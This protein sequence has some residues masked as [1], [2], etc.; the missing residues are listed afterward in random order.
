MAGADHPAD[1]L[2]CVGADMRGFHRSGHYIGGEISEGG[3]GC[4]N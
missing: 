2:C 3:G 1:H 4:T